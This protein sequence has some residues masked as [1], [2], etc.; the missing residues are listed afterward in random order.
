MATD[1]A[2]Q[3]LGDLVAARR[4][5][6]GLSKEAA[7]RLAGISSITWKRIEDGDP[8]QDA[9]YASASTALNW[10]PSAMENYL[11]DGLP[12]H[13]PS[14]A[15]DFIADAPDPVVETMLETIRKQ[16]PDWVYKWAMRVVDER[17][18]GR[19]AA[20]RNQGRAG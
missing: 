15:E 1:D 16:H 2:R 7:A 9:K 4:K 11:A 12:P 10:D 17:R 6:L 3:R 18:G 14:P 19:S 5:E 20:K 13:E 8:V